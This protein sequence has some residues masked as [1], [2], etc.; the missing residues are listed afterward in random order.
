MHDEE[1]WQDLCQRAS[2]EQDS[3]KLA[4]LVDEITRLLKEKSSRLRPGEVEPD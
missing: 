4:M 1:R 3:K 2:T